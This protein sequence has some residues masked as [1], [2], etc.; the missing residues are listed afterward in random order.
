MNEFS[1][2]LTKEHK[3][4]G[5]LDF[6]AYKNAVD[7]LNIPKTLVN[8]P[9]INSFYDEYGGNY[10]M[11][12]QRLKT[13]DQLSRN[14]SVP[15]VPRGQ[16]RNFRIFDQSG[17]DSPKRIKL[18]NNAVG[19]QRFLKQRYTNQGRL[20]FEL[21][22]MAQKGKVSPENMMSLVMSDCANR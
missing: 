12:K 16:S 4:G 19:V 9:A 7:K 18:K 11:I 1:A 13:S 15:L 17:I 2:S 3:K 5:R 20:K 8:V 21:D 10:K 14:P 22:T 6:D